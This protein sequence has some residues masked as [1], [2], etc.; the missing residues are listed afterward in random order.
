M[1]GQRSYLLE[2]DSRPSDTMPMLSLLKKY[3]LRSKVKIR[4]VSEEYDVWAAWGHSK[5]AQWETPRHWK[6]ARSGVVEP[7]WDSSE[8]PWGTDDESILDRRAVGMGRRFLV[9][10]GDRRK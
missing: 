9:K 7:K 2:H 10:K 1:T 8:W 4:D 5:Y 3:V 6:W